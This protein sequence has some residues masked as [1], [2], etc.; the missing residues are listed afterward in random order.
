MLSIAVPPMSHEVVRQH[1]FICEFEMISLYEYARRRTRTVTGLLPRDF[2]SP[3][4]TISPPEQKY[5]WLE[6]ELALYQVERGRDK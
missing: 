1:G 5:G 6:N 2:K 4:S 3:V